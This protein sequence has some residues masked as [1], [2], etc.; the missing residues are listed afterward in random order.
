M[1]PDW[2]RPYFKFGFVG[3][4]RITRFRLWNPIEPDHNRLNLVRVWVLSGRVGSGFLKTLTT[5]MV[6]R[7]YCMKTPYY[8]ARYKCWENIISSSLHL[9]S[10]EIR[11]VFDTSGWSWSLWLKLMFELELLCRA[12]NLFGK[13]VETAVY[14]SKKT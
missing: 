7:Y 13:V 12:E 1:K 8:I 10:L 11:G 5:T 2:T 9:R 6:Y 3:L 4:T 14:K